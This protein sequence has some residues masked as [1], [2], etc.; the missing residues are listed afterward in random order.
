M[1]PM[2]CMASDGTG[3]RRTVARQIQRRCDHDFRLGEEMTLLL[4]HRHCA[5][6]T[7]PLFLGGVSVDESMTM[8]MQRRGNGMG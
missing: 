6:V 4:R 1:L 2:K 8:E 5:V 3:R 7:G